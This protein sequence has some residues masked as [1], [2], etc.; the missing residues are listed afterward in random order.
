MWIT[1][2]I[3][4]CENQTRYTRLTSHPANR[5]VTI[6]INLRCSYVDTSS[7][8]KTNVTLTPFI[9]EGVDRSAHF[10]SPVVLCPTRES[11]PKP[12]VRQSHLRP[13]I[14]KTILSSNQLIVPVK[15]N[16]ALKSLPRSREPAKPQ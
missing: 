11:N 1:R 5:A 7:S 13:H 16:K 8:F 9:P 12:L 15:Q 2:R 10:S 6:L 4:P 3:A 14:F